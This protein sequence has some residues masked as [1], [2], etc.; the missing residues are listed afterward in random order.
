MI[1][2]LDHLA[3]PCSRDG[4]RVMSNPRL[5]PRGN[6]ELMSSP[7]LGEAAATAGAATRFVP[8]HLVCLEHLRR[9]YLDGAALQLPDSTPVVGLTLRYDKKDVPFQGWPDAR[10]WLRG[11][12]RSIGDTRTRMHSLGAAPI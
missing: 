11:M 8:V 9:T 3:P 6:F 10:D 5:L 12:Q 2:L 1:I 7:Q 4:G